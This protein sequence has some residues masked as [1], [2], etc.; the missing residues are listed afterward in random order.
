MKSI[1]W[2]ALELVLAPMTVFGSKLSLRMMMRMRT[3]LSF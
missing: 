3:F 1:S 2:D